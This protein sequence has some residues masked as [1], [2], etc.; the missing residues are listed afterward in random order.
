M[1]K[2]WTVKKFILELFDRRVAKVLKFAG[3]P[4]EEPHV[5]AVKKDM[6]KEP[7]ADPTLKVKSFV[8]N[9]FSEN[10]Y[11][12][13]D[14]SNAC[15]I[16]DPGCYTNEEQ[17]ELEQFISMQGLQPVR[18][19][20]THAHLDHMLGNAFV[21]RRWNLLPELHET[22]LQLLRSAPLYGELWGIRP[23][24]SPDPVSFL[25]EGDTVRFG[26]SSFDVLFVPGHCPGHIALLERN[27]KM[28]FSGD[29]VFQSSI[30]R[31]DLPGGDMDTLMRSIATGV[32]CLEDDV[33]IYSGHGPVTTVGAERRSNPFLTGLRS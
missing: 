23:E 14:E 30:G 1:K 8:F 5:A 28:L 12:I 19:I 33:K 27:Q 13:W 2:R 7:A 18:L 16:L 10:T 6:E 15:I 25:K 29:V 21:H 3:K 26:R 31:T 4:N 9:P 20:N 24:P 17:Q 22:D 11:V 32:L